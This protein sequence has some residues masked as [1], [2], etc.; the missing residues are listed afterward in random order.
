[1]AEQIINGVT[2][3]FQERLEQIEKHGRT[4]EYDVKENSEG[5]LSYAAEMLLAIGHEEGI[6]PQSYPWGWNKDICA[7]MLSKPYKERLV[8]AG[9]LIAAE[10][11]R[12]TLEETIQNEK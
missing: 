2:L 10:L 3:I 9:A 7:Y 1:M 4:L 5:Q 6:D 8:I 12:L 11:D